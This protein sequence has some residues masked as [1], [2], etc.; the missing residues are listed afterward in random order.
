MNGVEVGVVEAVG[1]LLDLMDMGAERQG[2]FFFP[3]VILELEARGLCVYSTTRLS[4]TQP[5]SLLKVQ[6]VL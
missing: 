6:Y 3:L 4:L 2:L 5:V 1:D